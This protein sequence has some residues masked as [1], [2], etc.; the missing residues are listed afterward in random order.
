MRYMGIDYGRKRVGVALSDENAE[1]AMPEVVLQNDGALYE[2]IN[3]LATDRGVC[4][5]V[6]G[7]SRDFSGKANKIQE[8]IIT[9]KKVLEDKYGLPV[10]LEPEI[11]TSREAS[12]IQGEGKMLDASAAALILK[13]YLD[14]HK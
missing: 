2:T 9:F 7:E 10:H 6:V 3:K 4:G 8:D 11:L 14:N 1:F 13:S 5:I 12:H